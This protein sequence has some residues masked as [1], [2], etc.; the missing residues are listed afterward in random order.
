MFIKFGSLVLKTL[1]KP[2][3][4]QIKAK[5]QVPGYIRQACLRYGHLHHKLESR[6]VLRLAGHSAKS[7]KSVS[8]DAAVGIGASVFSELFVFSV[9]GGL[10]AFELWKKDK[11]DM[12]AKRA[13][14]AA[15]AKEKRDAEERFLALEAEV[16]A[17]AH[18]LRNAQNAIAKMQ[19]HQ[20][21]VH[22]PPPPPTATTKTAK[23]GLW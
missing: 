3:A 19:H 8:D 20:H 22:R 6:A 11:D 1:T 16:T 5:A 18:A 7:V 17:M 10:L 21:D 2:V 4:N 13:K 23:W 12:A 9:A 15:A 14:D